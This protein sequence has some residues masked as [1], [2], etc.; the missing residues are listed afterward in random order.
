MIVWS[1]PRRGETWQTHLFTDEQQ[2]AQIYAS[3]FSAVGLVI[4]LYLLVLPLKAVYDLYLPLKRKLAVGVVF[5]TGILYA[6]F[7]NP[8]SEY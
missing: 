4:D 6:V 5:L 8:Q 3:P 2:Y 7:P 1:S